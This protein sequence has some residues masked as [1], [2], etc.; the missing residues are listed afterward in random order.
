[1]LEDTSFLDAALFCDLVFA[2]L[3]VTSLRN[4]LIAYPSCDAR[5][6]GNSEAYWQTLFK[7]VYAH[8]IPNLFFQKR[9]FQYAQQ[10]SSRNAVR[11]V[12]YLVRTCHGGFASQTRL[13]GSGRATPAEF[14]SL[15][16]T[17][18]RGSYFETST[19]RGYR[20]SR[21]KVCEMEQVLCSEHG[22]APGLFGPF[23]LLADEEEEDDDRDQFEQKYGARCL[24]HGFW[25][26]R[27]VSLRLC[28]VAKS[29]TGAQLFS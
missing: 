21:K 20:L 8:I 16:G 26:T 24:H 13:G 6:G 3:D 19:S 7:D 4:L 23:P 29:T 11:L 12:V 15:W 17:A 25:D 22:G 1:M 28:S 2:Y 10:G 27:C 14:L 9:L 5:F 18:Q